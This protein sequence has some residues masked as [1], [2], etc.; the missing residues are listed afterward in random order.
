DGRLGVMDFGMVGVI[1]EA[2]RERLAMLLGALTSGDAE[3]LVDTVLDMSAGRGRVDREELKRD[4]QRLLTRYY[5]LPLGQIPLGRML[6]EALAAVRRHR[7]QLPSSLALLFRALI[8][9]EGLGLRL[10]PDFSLGPVLK[11]FAERLL[12]QRYSPLRWAQRM[13]RAMIDTDHLLSELPRRLHRAL[14]MLDRG[15]FE[16]GLRRES[17]EPMADRLE[18]LANRIVLG[19]ITAAFIIAL[20]VLMLVYPPGGGEG[21]WG[22]TVFAV[23]LVAAAGLGVYLAWRIIRTGRG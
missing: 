7:L 9:S 11:P 22:G 3:R 23:G 8:V 1:D 16:F 12:L 10:D 2:G 17:L 14:K 6:E 13:G 19:M 4:I 15:G 5:E 20:S 18:R 21:H